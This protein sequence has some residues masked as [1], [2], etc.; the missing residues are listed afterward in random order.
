MLDG[1]NS[2]V[3]SDAMFTPTIKNERLLILN[4][5]NERLLILNN[6][7]ERLLLLNNF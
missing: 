6:L 5:L 1:F 3:G 7:N 2:M 4:N